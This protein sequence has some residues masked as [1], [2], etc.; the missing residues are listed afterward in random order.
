M[1]L[2]DPA[3]SNMWEHT[4]FNARLQPTEI[5]L[6]TTAADSSKLKLEYSYGTTNNNGNVLTQKITIGANVINQ[7]Y[8]YDGVN[9]L[10][11]AAET[12]AWSQSYG[13]DQ[14]GNRAVSGYVPNPT[15]TPQSL[16][17]FNATTN[18]ITMAGTIYDNA[19]NQTRDS[20]GSS[21][22]YDAENRQVSCTVSG[23]TSAYAYNG[24]GHR[25][26]KT[27]GGATTLFV[28]NIGGQLVAEYTTGA[29][30]GSGTSYLTTDHLGS[31]RV[32]SDASGNVKARHDYLPYGEE[33]ATTWSG[34]SGISGY[35]ATDSTR[36]RFTQKERDSESGLDYFGARYYS[37]AQARFTGVDPITIKRERLRDPQRLNLYAYV[38]NNPLVFYDPD[39]QDLQSDT[40]K[41]QGRIK[42]ALVE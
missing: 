26:T 22:G 15:L 42:K 7:S 20:A 8:T 17:A 28:Y 39:G 4:L 32:V 31:T 9:R 41:D 14:Y 40:S 21:F 6:G 13:Y 1:R 30:Q 23:V 16:S 3:T 18:Q 34:R 19:G 36:Q 12:G 37:S 24:E 33:V 27:T 25:I 2:S 35:A 5:G 11:T 38:R 29:P 10:G